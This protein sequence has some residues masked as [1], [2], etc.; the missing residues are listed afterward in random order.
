MRRLLLCFAILFSGML[1]LL[2][3]SEAIFGEKG[4]MR[5]SAACMLQRQTAAPSA[6]VVPSLP[7]SSSVTTDDREEKTIRLLIGDT[8]EVRTL[9]L[10]E[11]VTGVVL[12]E[13]PVSFAPDALRAQA[14]AARTHTLYQSERGVRHQNA[15]ICSDSACC[16]AWIDRTQA[17][18][19]WGEEE[20]KRM[21][22]IASGA[23][24]DTAGEILL[25][26]SEP[27]CAAFHASSAG[28]TASSA[29]VWGG[30]LAY[31]VSVS[32][33]ET[34]AV[35]T[36]TVSDERF[37]ALLASAGCTVSGAPE[38]WIETIDLTESGRVAALTVCGQSF[39]GTAFRRLFS[40]SSA[41]FSVT[42]CDGA[43]VIESAGSGH[44]VGMSQYGAD[45]MARS[46]EDYR[47]ILAHYYPGTVLAQDSSREDRETD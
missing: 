3:A 47:A 43:F 39:S 19:L 41:S 40:L 32:T 42:F 13:M 10:E 31:L 24:S 45:A 30:V 11:Y 8:G 26:Q 33:P 44:G 34:A 46:G 14:V 23:V 36:L 1:L 28:R 15:D 17:E 12:A 7:G 22:K 25:W 9:P 35:R 27:I 37:A 2:T 18:A 20:A 21:W 29:E 4:E 16:Q 5:I 38:G 6:S